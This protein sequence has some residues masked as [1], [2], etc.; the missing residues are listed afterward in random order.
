MVSR[1]ATEGARP[2]GRGARGG[3][4]GP[5]GKVKV[6]EKSEGKGGGGGG[7]RKEGNG[8]VGRVPS[9]DRR[10]E[11]GGQGAGGATTQGKARKGRKGEQVVAERDV[12]PGTSLQGSKKKIGS[13]KQSATRSVDVSSEKKVSQQSTSNPPG[14][15]EHK[16][17][18]DS[19]MKNAKSKASSIFLNR[20]SSTSNAE[21][22]DV[23]NEI[24]PKVPHKDN[25]SSQEKKSD[26]AT[27][28]HPKPKSDKSQKP[29]TDVKVEE[30][31]RKGNV[32]DNELRKKRK[33][34]KDKATLAK[35]KLSRMKKL[36]FL[37][38]PPRR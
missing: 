30:R 5:R 32:I 17:K 34:K 14:S 11:P 26:S 13:V 8:G 24:L 33:K 36:G 16:K 31:D 25:K 6:R 12:A 35:R 7:G 27:E 38:A 28:K 1:G 37:S 2:G 22:T 19:S 20:P 9:P 29:K 10:A 21:N 18:K 23:E 3:V 4:K 15:K